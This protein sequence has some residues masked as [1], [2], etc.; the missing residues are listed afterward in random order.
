MRERKYSVICI[1]EGQVTAGSKREAQRL[2]EDSLYRSFDERATKDSNPS[3]SRIEV[4]IGGHITTTC[5]MNA[6][7]WGMVGA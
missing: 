3:I 4:C 7:A 6:G 1:L 2:M 5:G